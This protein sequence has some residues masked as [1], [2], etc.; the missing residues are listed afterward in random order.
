MTD[1]LMR[2]DMLFLTANGISDAKAR[3]RFIYPSHD[4]SLVEELFTQAIPAILSTQTSGHSLLDVGFS[5]P[6][7]HGGVRVRAA[8]AVPVGD[9]THICT[10]YGVAQKAA[11]PALDRLLLLGND[12]KID[13]GI[14]GAAALEALTGLEYLT[15]QSDIDIVIRPK[16]ED[17]DIT[18]FWHKA[19][20]ISHSCGVKLDI[21][22]TC[23]DGFGVK[24][25]E[26][27]GS[28]LT[29][30]GK[31]KDGAKLLMR[32]LNIFRR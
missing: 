15:V 2:H 20:E 26:L 1:R 7:K 21:E 32:D 31:H 3:A 18:M 19:C 13:V 16:T 29:V 22:A 8:S 23:A 27:F 11:I 9:I 4:I 24:L 25:S 10:P 17:A 12:C 30:L 5:F 14:F 6:A 28:A